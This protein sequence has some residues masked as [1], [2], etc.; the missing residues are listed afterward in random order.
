MMEEIGE[1]SQTSNINAKWLD[2]VYD[3]IKRIEDYERLAREGCLTL[4]DFV[5]IPESQRNVTLGEAQFKNLKMLVTEFS[6]L[7]SDLSPVIKDNVL[8]DFRSQLRDIDNA[9]NNESW[10]L[11][12]I[13]NT[14]R[15]VKQVKLT[16]F[17]YTSLRF[18]SN[19]KI[20]LFKEIRHIL[21]IQTT[22]P[23]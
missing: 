5:S 11:K 1:I 3:N 18:V 6:L 8:E 15:Q 17:F 10:F 4:L 20:K 22:T 14:S 2:N 16:D 12:R 19:L 9:L 23:W 7:M 21:Y 13:Y